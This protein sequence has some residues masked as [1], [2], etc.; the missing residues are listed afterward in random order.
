M[1][2][3]FMFIIKMRER[4]GSMKDRRKI[5]FRMIFIAAIAVMTLGF[6]STANV[7][8]AATDDMNDGVYFEQPYADE[9]TNLT[10]KYDG[11][12]SELTYKWFV[13]GAETAPAA[14]G[15]FAVTKDHY[16]KT[17]RA[18]VWSGESK[19]GEAS[20]F[21]SKLPV[22][23]IDIEDGAEVVVK[24]DYLDAQ[25]HLQGNDQFESGKVLYTGATEI[26]GRG[27]STWE[28]FPK[29]PYKLKLDKKADLFGLGKNKH[30]VLLANYIDESGM[31][32]M[33]AGD[34]ATRMGVGAMDGT[35][36]ELVI[37]GQPRGMYQLCE[38]VRLSEDRVNVFDWESAAEDIAEAIAES[39][40]FSEDD[41]DALTDQMAE[42]DMSWISSGEV[43]FGG[44]TYKTADYYENLPASFSG[45]YLLEMDY[46][47]DEVSKFTTDKGAKLMFKSPEFINTDAVAM[48]T[49]QDYVQTFEDA[50][51]SKDFNTKDGDRV[52]SY[53][54]FCDMESMVSFWLA[55]EFMMNEIGCKSTY[56]QKDID[57]PLIFGPV[58]DFDFS[59]GAISPFS[60]QN[61]ADWTCDNKY[62]GATTEKWWF[63]SAMKDP[64][65]AV[66]A[67]SL[68]L[69]QE[70]YL[71]NVI[72]D[73][74]LL[75]EWH[76]YLA[77]SGRYNYD[78]WQYAE[79]F[80]ADYEAL[81]AWLTKRINWM[82]KQFATNTSAIKSLAP[83]VVYS[84]KFTLG[85]QGENV[86]STGV[87]SYTAPVGSSFDLTVTVKSGQYSEFNYYIN[88][89][90]QGTAPLENGKAAIVIRED[91]LTEAVNEDNV[92]TVWLK[93]A[94][95]NL[96]E[97]QY[98]IVKLTSEKQFCNVVFNDMGG[99]HASKVL[100]GKKVYLDYPM[101]Q[102]ADYV[103][104][105][106]TDGTDVYKAGEWL[107]VSDNI[108]LNAVWTTCS[109]GGLSHTLK[110]DGEVL[111]CTAEGC[112]ASKSSGVTEIDVRS[113]I[114]AV[115]N[116]YSNY[117]TGK[118]IRPVITLTYGKD[119]VLN[120]DYTVEYKNNINIGYATY[121]VKAVKGSGF[122]GEYTLSYRILPRK[123][124]DASIKVPAKCEL[125]NGAAEPV[126][127]ITYGG[128]TLVEGTDYEVAYSDNTA[129]GTGSAVITG[130][131]NFAESITK[132][133]EV[134]EPV[135]DI[136]AC[137]IT[138]ALGT[139]AYTGKAIKPVI[140][141]KNGSVKLI[142][143]THY[144]VTYSNNTKCGTATV[145][146]TGIA[147]NG[148]K[149]T[150]TLTFKI[151]PA[152]VNAKVTNVKY[153]QQKVTWNKVTGVTK[154]N[155]YRS[156]DNKTFKLVKTVKSSEER[157]YNSKNLKPGKMYYY[158][159]RAV[160]AQKSG[161]KTTN[162]LG[163]EAAPVKLKPVLYKGNIK[164]LENTAKRTVTIKWAGTNGAHGYKIYRSTTNKA[165]S[166][167][168]I[169]TVKLVKTYKDK[170]LKK[171][172]TYYYK[173]RAYRNVDGKI[174]YGELS[175]SKAVK[176][177][178]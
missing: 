129:I 134:I 94:N 162:Y 31:R 26:K 172:K 95:G 103:F 152:K 98:M 132:T 55:S 154:Y 178:K 149:G 48:K 150:K 70:E 120:E 39:N 146:I 5:L 28:Y 144:K 17:I 47:Y 67:R 25:M 168:V 32:N 101:N 139:K 104:E 114:L 165:G 177:K 16:E 45:G 14:D 72:A 128:K 82:D 1:Q 35:W 138:A 119:L 140:T 126:I 33:L 102:E 89:K 157:V 141:V 174:V 19:L 117:Y 38:H 29:K 135:T 63:N 64:Y 155:V 77:E 21:C 125:K 84:N 41:M 53:T 59:S 27:N 88:S 68:Y 66:K 118:E 15:S 96:A 22:L 79:G 18:E 4:L 166:F 23:Y 78:M 71:K 86:K 73:D 69:Q 49:V 113:C 143:G 100:S 11:T 43:T 122:K 34:F 9:G 24:D 110:A 60:A 124:A 123:I 6:S 90:F 130:K 121:T 10:V 127:T 40:G 37:N 81:D 46:G 131:G 44:N 156:A 50:L 171:G 3:V 85:L 175:K 116:R 30:W 91:Q 112:T 164:S 36:V 108:M 80:D 115:S 109:D 148:Y 169:K 151:R 65:F 74:G 7:S 76:D 51:Y 176:I 173:V 20:M 105:G 161:D 12:E 160:R 92:I 93:D 2:Y 147:D 136:S 158:K 107:P 111:N 97:Q 56:F 99:T 75:A 57:Q 142:S 167:K 133:F 8:Y 170:N 87:N 62:W 42:E 58:W 159:V 153:N 145:K 83:G 13:D 106:W 52:V 163:I 137:K 54:E 61:P